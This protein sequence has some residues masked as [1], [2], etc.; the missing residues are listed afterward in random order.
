MAL[1]TAIGLGVIAAVAI[2]FVSERTGFDIGGLLTGEHV[3]IPLGGIELHWNWLV[4]CL[5]TLVAWA[6]LKAT[7]TR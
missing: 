3:R 6:S 7:E 5:V 1:A 4:F 2:P